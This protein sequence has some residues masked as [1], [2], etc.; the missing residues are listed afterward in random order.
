MFAFFISFMARGSEKNEK[1]TYYYGQDMQLHVL[2]LLYNKLYYSIILVF[3]VSRDFL[4]IVFY[5]L[6]T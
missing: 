6:M 4:N 5:I 2:G 1:Q 3:L